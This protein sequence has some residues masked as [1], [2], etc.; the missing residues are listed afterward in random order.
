MHFVLFEDETP[1]EIKERGLD[2][3]NNFHSACLS[4]G[5]KSIYKTRLLILGQDDAGKI[6]LKNALVNL[7]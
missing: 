5:S 6:S 1:Y 4:G 2:A 7:K 3:I